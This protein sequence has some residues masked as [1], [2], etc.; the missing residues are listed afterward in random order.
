MTVELKVK[1]GLWDAECGR[2]GKVWFMTACCHLCRALEKTAKESTKISK[3]TSFI[4]GDLD[5]VV[6]GKQ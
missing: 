1:L 5:L 6:D 3:Y 2:S 4:V